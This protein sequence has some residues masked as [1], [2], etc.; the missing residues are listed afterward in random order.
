MFT[1]I[2]Q[3]QAQ[4]LELQDAPASRLILVACPWNDIAIGESVAVNGTCLTVTVQQPGRF[5]TQICPETLQRTQLGKLRVGDYVNLERALRLS[6]RLSGHFVQGHID[7]V[8]QLQSI[9]TEQTTGTSGP[10]PVHHQIDAGPTAESA[11]YRLVF[12]LAQKLADYCV[13]KGS[14]TLN[15]VSLTLANVHWSPPTRIEV[16]VIAHTWAI[17]NLQRLQVGD[18]VNVEIDMLAKMTA[19]F[20]ARARAR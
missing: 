3:E 15:G 5:S 11:T 16:A 19:E 13:E 6:D 10:A 18:W 1:G 2:V 14:I 7:G 12:T 9:R 20:A 8:A 4:I 17:T